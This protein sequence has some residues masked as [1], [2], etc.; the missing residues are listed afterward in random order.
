MIYLKWF[1]IVKLSILMCVLSLLTSCSTQLSKTLGSADEPFWYSWGFSGKISIKVNTSNQNA[2]L[3]WENVGNDYK[4]LLYGPLGQG[5]I[6]IEKVGEQLSLKKDGKV[7][8]ADSPEALLFD[9]TGLELPISSLAYWVRGLTNP[10]FDAE[11]S[12]SFDGKIE[13]IA[14]HGWNIRY[15]S[16]YGPNEW[17]D[18]EP[19]KRKKRSLTDSSI[20][21]NLFPTKAR[22]LPRK[23]VLNKTSANENDHKIKVIIVIKE[24][25]P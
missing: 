9:T 1:K 11:I 4:I 23:I 18:G 15:T 22:H 2:N 21:A 13:S 19:S 8:Y 12:E 3:L 5:K 24:W 17:I 6:S 10:E 7:H 16:Y 25:Q 20:A 14:Q